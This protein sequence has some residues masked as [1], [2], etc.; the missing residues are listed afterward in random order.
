MISEQW[1]VAWQQWRGEA[2]AEAAGAG[3]LLCVLE[4]A[5]MPTMAWSVRVGTG[6]LGPCGASFWSGRA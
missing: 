5:S 4:D 2:K 6:E 3:R 1:R